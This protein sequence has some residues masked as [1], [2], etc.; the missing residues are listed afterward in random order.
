MKSKPE[1]MTEEELLKKDG[2]APDL[3][4]KMVSKEQK[5]WENV[6]KNVSNQNED[7]ENQIKINNVILHHAKSMIEREKT[8]EKERQEKQKKNG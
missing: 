3:G 8:L 1:D 2:S 6:A 4:L 7:L 5:F